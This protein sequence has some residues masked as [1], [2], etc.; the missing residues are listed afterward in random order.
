[1]TSKELSTFSDSQLRKLYS[2]ISA[3]VCQ[4]TEEMKEF[5]EEAAWAAETPTM[6]YHKMRR[7]VAFTTIAIAELEAHFTKGIRHESPE[8]LE[9]SSMEATLSSSFD[10][11]GFDLVLNGFLS[12]V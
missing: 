2:L 9:W 12:A 5:N 3:L 6:I 4:S 1:M 10:S 11:D 7:S 8:T